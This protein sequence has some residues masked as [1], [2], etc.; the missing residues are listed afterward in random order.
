[1]R[2]AAAA[3]KVHS[4][5]V[6]RIFDHGVTDGGHPFIVMEY[7][8][9]EDLGRLLQ[10]RSRLE[11]EQVAHIVDQAGRALDAAHRR[12]IVHR[13]V[14]P[15]NIFLIDVGARHPHV[16]LVDFGVAKANQLMTL[17]STGEMVGTPVYM[18][19]EQIAAQ[20]VDH[21]SDLWSLGVVAFRALTG[22]RPFLGDTVA[23]VTYQVVH[24]PL[25]HPGDGQPD[26]ER[27]VDEWF[28]QACAKAREGRFASAREMA[29]ALWEAI[30]MPQ[31]A[32]WGSD[33]THGRGPH[34]DAATIADLPADHE[35]ATTP[36]GAAP[37]GAGQPTA[38]SLRSSVATVAPRPAS[39]WRSFALAR[40]SPGLGPRL[41]HRHLRIHRG[42]HRAS[43]VR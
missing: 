3:A 28:A 38:G 43:W 24:A 41:R 21:R 25:P 20:E 8:E 12:G 36:Y 6:V 35:L 42:A 1:M 7:L 40:D 33:S 5:H 16:K 37:A 19:P 9:G 13:D 11:L 27:P 17:T 34:R 30:G 39:R 2:E 14:K 22:E 32:P 23:S 4:P 26:L 15:A 10:Q 18:S 29:D 31:S